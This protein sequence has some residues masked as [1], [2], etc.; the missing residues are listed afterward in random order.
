LA[1]A[2]AYGTGL[3][4]GD[5]GVIALFGSPGHPTLPV[6]LYQQL[7]SYRIDAAAATGLWLILILLALFSLFNRLG[8]P[9]RKPGWT[10]NSPR[11]VTEPE[12][13]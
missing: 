6:L 3:S 10:T 8:T 11:T 9:A 4:L 1:L 2:M 13:A 7:G 5:F 12:H